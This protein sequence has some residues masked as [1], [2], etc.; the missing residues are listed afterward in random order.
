MKIPKSITVIYNIIGI[1]FSIYLSVL[2]SINVNYVTDNNKNFYIYLESNDKRYIGYYPN[3]FLSLNEGKNYQLKN[4]T[5]NNYDLFCFCK[6]SPNFRMFD[7]NLCFTSKECD[8]NI[9]IT[10]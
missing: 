6:N 1:G 8:S 4:F 9:R 10:P 3:V 7:L 2:Y 5:F